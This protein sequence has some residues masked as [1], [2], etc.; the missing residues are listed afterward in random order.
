M[1]LHLMLISVDYNRR[2]SQNRTVSPFWHWLTAI[3]VN[4]MNHEFTGTLHEPLHKNS[5]DARESRYG[6]F[7]SR[8]AGLEELVHDLRQPLSTI[9]CLTYYLELICPDTQAQVQLRQIQEMIL[10]ANHILERA[11]AGQAN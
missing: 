6:D 1:F 4:S 7:H 11:S 5:N 8:G 3:A 2:Q 10:Q 9:E